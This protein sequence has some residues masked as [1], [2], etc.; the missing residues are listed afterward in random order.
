M[1]S[2]LHRLA[3]LLLVATTAT[4]QALAQAEGSSIFRNTCAACHNASGEGTA[5]IA[6]AL[7][8]TLA[9]FGKSEEGR[10]YI[11]QVLLGGLSGRIVSQGQVFMGAMPPQSA[12]SDTDLAAVA[13]YVVKD[14]N[15][16]AADSFSSAEFAAARGTKL[17]HKE[18][19]EM[20]E[21]L[22]K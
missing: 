8:G 9:P 12:L 10:R 14:L 6:P 13:N 11:A 17:S 7:A 21:R 1:M 16:G 4:G 20:R 2:K 19:R 22:S 5:G 18:L 3:A 15:G